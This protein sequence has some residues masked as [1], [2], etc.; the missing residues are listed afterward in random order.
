MAEDSVTGRPPS[1]P[2]SSDGHYSQGDNNRPRAPVVVKPEPFTPP[3]PPASIMSDISSQQT[4]GS[5]DDPSLYHTAP[6]PV[7]YTPQQTMARSVP[8][9]TPP[10][11]IGILTRS[12]RTIG[13]PSS[14]EGTES[15][16]ASLSPKSRKNLRK[17]ASNK[18]GGP[19]VEQPLSIL[20][21]DYTTPVR[22]MALWVNRPVEER[23]AEVERKK[24]YIS[25]PMNSFMLYRSA[26]AERVKQ[27]CKENNHQV[28]SQVTG[29]S[30]PLEPKEVRDLYE[31]YAIVE[32]DNH[33]AAH[34]NYKFAPN[35]AG[36]RTRTEGDVSD[37]DPEWE[38]S[39][40]SSK[41]SRSVRRFE[42]R[43]A[44]STPFEERPAVYHRVIPAQHHL[45]GYEMSNPYAPAPI[46]VSSNGMV[47]DYYQA[48]A[49]VGPYEHVPDITYRRLED[50]FSPYQTTMG[51]VALPH[52]EHHELLTTYPAPQP[53]AVPVQHDM[54][55]PRLGQLDPNY[56]LVYY[57]GG[58]ESAHEIPR[59]IAYESAPQLELGYQ[60]EVYHP[61]LATLTEEHDVWAD[62]GQ[63]GSD[64][65][66]EFQ[67][68]S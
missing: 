62:P 63:A 28:V 21:K 37:S 45:S 9:H 11:N 1:P 24:G 49:A 26:Y 20:T 41:R 50:A 59:T 47:G 5:Y 57:E 52:A 8:S 53:V 64:F 7:Y 44:S 35:K 67:K 55:D 66:S 6:T 36:K 32:R 60:A 25:R 33:A 68:M 19:V 30:W 54:L 14:P 51:L 4:Y 31:R 38:G 15:S 16:R 48:A 29:A 42:S 43:S 61:G 17:K 13:T 40:K 34:P 10:Q 39:V 18:K 56:Q 23:L 65:D 46:M 22:D 2:H 27:F 58:A 3:M 12:G